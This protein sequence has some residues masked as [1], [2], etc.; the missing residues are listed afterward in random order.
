MAEELK[1]TAKPHQTDRRAFSRQLGR[2]PSPGSL[3]SHLD[4]LDQARTVVNRAT[5]RFTLRRHLQVC[6]QV[7]L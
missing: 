2:N 6:R 5:A 7:C 1:R 3:A 4:R